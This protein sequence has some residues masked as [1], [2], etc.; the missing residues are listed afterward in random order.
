MTLAEAA[1]RDPRLLVL[2]CTETLQISLERNTRNVACDGRF[3]VR[4]RGRLVF[5]GGFAAA[6]ARFERARDAQ[7]RRRRQA[8]GHPS[9]LSPAL[10]RSAPGRRLPRARRP[11]GRYAGQRR[12]S[13][14]VLVPAAPPEP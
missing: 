8:A 13:W 10:R 7:S 14:R 1:R 2:R 11:D 6:A 12:V 9:L 4:V 3:H 5:S